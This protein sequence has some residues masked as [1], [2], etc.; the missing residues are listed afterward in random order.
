MKWKQF[1]KAQALLV[2]GKNKAKESP[3][4]VDKLSFCLFD[5]PINYCLLF[6]SFFFLLFFLSFLTSYSIVGSLGK[7]VKYYHIPDNVLNFLAY[8]PSFKP[9]RI[10]LSSTKT[11][12]KYITKFPQR[13]NIFSSCLDSPSKTWPDLS[14]PSIVLGFYFLTLI[15]SML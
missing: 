4:S 11:W 6:S 2:C 8:V 13:I 15:C 9:L 10:I 12:V 14:S 5:H 7:L 1:L 3:S